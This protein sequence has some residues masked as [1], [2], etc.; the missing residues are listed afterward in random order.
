[1][2]DARATPSSLDEL[3]GGATERTPIM[4][5]D[6]KSGAR[7]ERVVIGG[8]HHVLKHLHPDDD[9]IMRATG[10][11]GCR[12]VAVWTSGVLAGLPDCIDHAIVGAVS[13]LGRNGLGGAVLMRDVSSQLVPEGSAPIGL[14]RHRSFL[15]HM[16]TLHA[17][18]WTWHDDIGLTPTMHRYLEFSPASVALEANRGWPDP[19]PALI[20][21]GWE[22][23]AE[24]DHPAVGPLLELVH[25]PTPLVDALGGLPRT[26]LHGDWKAGNLGTTTDGRTILLDWAVP[27]EGCPTQELAWYLAVN[28]DR[29]PHPK[30]DAIDVYRA[31]LEDQGVATEAWWDDALA[32]AL[33]GG[34]VWFGWEKALGGPGPELDWWLRAAARGL[35]RL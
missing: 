29:L 12:P 16:A 13:G 31:A 21:D 30:E 4:P 19:V 7:F 15:E 11:L 3:L 10:D 20:V 8:R 24:V 14:A 22:A 32:L 34:V 6:S 27:G 23:F 1:M 9:W 17:S 35:E 25:D 33:L 2:I 18:Y 26:F 28:T 5:G